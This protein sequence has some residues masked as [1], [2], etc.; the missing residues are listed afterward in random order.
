MCIRDRIRY[1]K[2]DLSQPNIGN[3]IIEEKFVGFYH[4]TEDSV[5]NFEKQIIKV[6]DNKNIKLEK[7]RGQGYDGAANMRGKYSGLQARIKKIVP[8]AE[9]I[10]CAAHN[11]NLVLNDSVKDITALQIFL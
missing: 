3:F 8:N 5:E 9:Y 4:I 2:I 6:L 7:C 11:L 10:H 1:V